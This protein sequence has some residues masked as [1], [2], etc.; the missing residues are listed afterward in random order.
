MPNTNDYVNYAGE[1]VGLLSKK[2]DQKKYAI[3][4]STNQQNTQYIVSTY[5]KDN[6]NQRTVVFT[7]ILANAQRPR[8][9]A[10]GD[11]VKGSYDSSVD[12]KDAVFFSLE[13]E[14]E[15]GKLDSLKKL[16]DYM[17]T[18]KGL[19]ELTAKSPF[20]DGYR[21]GRELGQQVGGDT[22]AT[23]KKIT[24]LET[25]VNRLSE[26]ISKVNSLTTKQ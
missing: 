14:T 1:L 20:I 12:G 4:G 23:Q 9:Y 5:P 11:A 13:L 26:V 17:F 19:C 22:G 18:F 3:E 15:N 2:I 7:V 8:G 16:M 24:D 25:E 6:V 10:N 21:K